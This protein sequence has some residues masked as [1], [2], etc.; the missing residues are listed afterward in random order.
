MTIDPAQVG[1]SV[2]LTI[3]AAVPIPVKKGLDFNFVATAR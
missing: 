2:L 1:R 3:S